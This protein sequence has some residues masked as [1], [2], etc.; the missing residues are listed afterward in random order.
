M[1]LDDN[2]ELNLNENEELF[3]RT[4]RID[5]HP[6]FLGQS[7]ERKKRQTQIFQKT[8][9]GT[10]SETVKGVELSADF[11][12]LFQSI[13]D[14][15]VITDYSGKIQMLNRR[16]EDFFLVAE[17]ELCGTS[18]ID[19]ISGAEESLIDTLIANLKDNRFTLIDAVCMR[20]DK[21]SFPAEIAV[22]KI[23]LNDANFLSFFVR[24]ITVRKR[25]Q[26]ALEKAVTR[27]EAHDRSRLQFISNVYYDKKITYLIMS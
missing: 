27:L 26:E 5:I 13:Y 4:Q 1:A 21:S 23:I 7:L 20:K 22:N 10:I 15:I 2:N 11:T 14:A 8:S 6:D 25:T 18:I 17:G 19:L 3:S 9:S 12:N 24:D 16:A